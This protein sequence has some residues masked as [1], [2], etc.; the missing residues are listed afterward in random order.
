MDKGPESW[1]IIFVLF[2]LAVI[3][4]VPLSS[5]PGSNVISRVASVFQIVDQGVLY[6]DPWSNKTN[7]GSEHD[8]HVYS[9]KAPGTSFIGVPTYAIYKWF[10][11]FTNRSVNYDLARHLVRITTLLPFCLLAA[12]LAM[13]FLS[14]AGYD[15]LWFAP[16]WL[17]GTVA[18]PFSLLYFGH[19]FAATFIFISFI[20]LYTLKTI[21]ARKDSVAIPIFAGLF[22]GLAI[23]TEYPTAALALLLGLYLLTFERR[24]SR[25]SLFGVFGAVLPAAALALYNW[26]CF[27]NP[28]SFGYRNLRYDYFQEGMGTG[29]MGVGI[30][31]LANLWE[32]TFSAASGLFFTAPWLL[33]AP[34]G[35]VVLLL[36][37][38]NRIE[39]MLFGLMGAAYFAFNAGYYEAGGAASFGPRH[40]IPVVPF[41]SVAAF[42]GGQGL[43]KKIKAGFY[44]L[45]VFSIFLTSLGTF[46]DPTMPDRLKNP[47]MEFALPLLTHGYGLESPLGLSGL[48]L[49]ALFIGLLIILWILVRNRQESI[50]AEP[51]QR[52][53][54]FATATVLL[55]IYL[56]I[57]PY[58]AH[59]G[60]G[61]KHQVLGNYYSEREQW[62]AAEKEYRL[63]ARIRID[64][65]IH[66]YR[67]RALAKL[68]RLTEMKYEFEKT[69]KL[70]PDFHHKEML[71]RI[72]EQ[73]DNE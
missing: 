68:G 35:I 29:I 33:F 26:A 41:L 42:I 32:V 10:C 25:V 65:N 11:K 47:L 12:W 57:V 63:A 14:R 24:I 37:K 67:G 20:L 23:F 66:Y 71:Q 16:A 40:L 3:L 52:N 5:Y 50:Y 22:A 7:D 64:P 8:G 21:P 45:I 46:A 48:K 62:S 19:Q 17:F 28:F 54:F 38:N 61:I 43:G 58:T 13:R 4:A 49:F 31:T 56:F 59:S 73:V 51:G 69:L 6:I 53:A 36:K 60:P 55:L 27:G 70:A 72:L 39:G 18:F 44:A 15:S 9:D 2:V 34:L 1:R 30:P